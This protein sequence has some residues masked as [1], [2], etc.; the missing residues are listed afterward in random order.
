VS[1]RR[2]RWGVAIAALV[3][4]VALVPTPAVAS[5]GSGPSAGA[6]AQSKR[7]VASREHQVAIAANEVAQAKLALDRLN[8]SA[9]V[10]FEA[11]DNARVK[12]HAARHAVGTA[13]R[14]LALATR[15]VARGQA[16]VSKFVTA[17]YESG[18]LSTISAY[19]APGGPAQLVSRVGTINAIS[20]S[21]H[22]TLEQ[23]DA[24]RIY[25]AVVSR[26]AEAVEAN[27]AAD[28]VVANRAKVAALAAVK[29]QTTL[30][31]G[32]RSQRAHLRAL[33]S[34]ART[35]ASRVEH[36]RLEAIVRARAAAAARAAASH[37]SGPPSP[38]STESGSTAGTVSASTASTALRDA[39]SQIGKAYQWGAAGPNTYDCSGLVLWA[40]GH[41]GVH[42]EHFTGDQWNEG[43]HI[44][45]DQLRPGDL[46]FFATNTSDP[47]TIHHVGLYVGGGEMVDAPFTGADVRYDSMDRPDYIGA[48]RPYQR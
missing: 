23:L 12:L 27:A 19:L 2:L 26:Q 6:V 39:E 41:V 24:A 28:A 10:A 33:L 7:E 46:V 45:R 35:H 21:E 14:V 36:E 29:R 25:Q 1:A 8:V 43:A 38:Y 31:A 22:T 15:Q 5:H 32:L 48:V 34:R 37:A 30:L 47:A 17:A 40:Y 18:G 13:H 16:R 4:S 44:S 9:E 42:L 3:T 20:A 11:Y